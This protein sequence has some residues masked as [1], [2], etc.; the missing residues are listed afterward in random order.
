MHELEAAKIEIVEAKSRSQILQQ[1]N[2]S[3]LSEVN[4]VQSLCHSQAKELDRLHNCQA[5]LL[6]LQNRFKYEDE[7]NTSTSESCSIDKNHAQNSKLLSL[8]RQNTFNHNSLESA[9]IEKS[10][11]P[12]DQQ[13]CGFFC[14]PL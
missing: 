10:K 6:E 9:K 8:R 12:V 4:R 5:Q 2:D 3:L 1:E 14:V 13:Q 7:I 11:H